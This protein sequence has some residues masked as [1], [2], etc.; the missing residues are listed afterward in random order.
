VGDICTIIDTEGSW[1][2]SE[3]VT[4]QNGFIE[5]FHSHFRDEFLTHE[6]LRSEVEAAVIIEHWRRQHDT[7]R[8]HS[9][10]GCKTPAQMASAYAT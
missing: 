6:W 1:S 7:G 3:I 5:S 9:A 2:A 8:P 10:L 4:R